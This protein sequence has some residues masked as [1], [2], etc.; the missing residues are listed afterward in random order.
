MTAS[1]VEIYNEYIIDLLKPK[2]KE[3]LELWDDPVAGTVVAGVKE[4]EVTHINEVPAAHQMMKLLQ[5]ANNRRTTEAT[6]AND[7]SSRSHAILQLT[8]YKKPRVAGFEFEQKVGK[9]NMIDLAGSERGSVTENRGIRLFEGAKINR[10]LLALA[11]CINALGDKSKKGTFVPYRDSKLTRLLKDSLGGKSR[12]LMLCAIA[13]GSVM[14]EETLNTLKYANRAKEIK[15]H[16]E[17]NKKVV[18]LHIAEYKGIIDDLRKEIED[19]NK[20]GRAQLPNLAEAAACPYCS[21]PLEIE[22]KIELLKDLLDEQTQLRK[23]VSEIRAQNR[24]NQFDM[25]QARADANKSDMEDLA[26]LEKSVDFNTHMKWDM[27]QRIKQLSEQIN[28]LLGTIEENLPSQDARRVVGEVVQLKAIEIENMELEINL[29]FYEQLNRLMMV[30]CKALQQSLLEAGIEPTEDALDQVQEEDEH[31]DI[32]ETNRE[33]DELKKKMQ[34]S[35]IEFEEFVPEDPGEDQQSQYDGMDLQAES[36]SEDLD[37]ER[38]RD[39]SHTPDRV[40][41]AKDPPQEPVI[42]KPP[43]RFVD[44]DEEVEID[45]IE[46]QPRIDRDTEL[47]MH[48]R[49]ETR[50]PSLGHPTYLKFSEHPDADRRPS[51]HPQ[52]SA[53]A[54]GLGRV[55][56]RDDMLNEMNLLNTVDKSKLNFD[57]QAVDLSQ[58]RFSTIRGEK[59]REQVH[60][61]LTIGWGEEFRLYD[62]EFFPETTACFEAEIPVGDR[63]FVELLDEKELRLLEQFELGE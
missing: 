60:W 45:Q 52:N 39:P 10:S 31:A 9:L 54:S 18:E 16:V 61:N 19:L 50:E 29:K 28:G 25:A 13:P 14:F 59:K 5:T 24:Q 58:K 42:E 49:I 55:V 48:N 44:S 1:F 63:D 30:E 20:I 34:E 32:E 37:S 17:E 47:G 15:V 12:T 21:V 4:V 43:G 8:V 3:F 11:N 26:S 56:A 57:N 2:N 35:G 7:T 36:K 53:R 23:Q 22:K 62:G 41:R 27:E 40:L 6:K 51:E 33:I 38:L 46:S